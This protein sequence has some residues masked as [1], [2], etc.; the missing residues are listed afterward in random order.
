MASHFI[1]MK[2]ERSLNTILFSFFHLVLCKIKFSV[3]NVHHE[4]C[5]IRKVQRAPWNRSGIAHHHIYK[6]SAFRQVLTAIG[7]VINFPAFGVSRFS[8]LT[9]RCEKNFVKQ[10]K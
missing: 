9:V 7:A 4:Q 5:G 2:K 10:L 1:N 3:A 8:T 6:S